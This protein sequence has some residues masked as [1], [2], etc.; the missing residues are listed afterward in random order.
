MTDRE[1]RGT[2]LAIGPPDPGGAAVCAPGPRLGSALPSQPTELVYDT[3]LEVEARS[4]WAFARRRFVRHRLA[5]GSL[6]VLL[7]VFGCRRLRQRHRALLLLRREHQRAD[8]AA[9]RTAS[10]RHRP[11]GSR[12]LQPGALRHP[13]I[14][15]GRPPRRLPLDGPRHHRRR[16]RRLLRRLGGQRPDAD[17]R[18]LFDLTPA[19]GPVDRGEIPRS[20]RAH[21]SG[22]AL[23]LLHLAD[24]RPH[25]SRNLSFAARE[26][27]R[28][29][30]QGV[31]IG[32]HPDHVQAHDPEH[33]RADPRR[34]DAHDRYRDPARVRRCR[35]SGSGSS[36]RRPRSVCSSARARI[37]ASPA[38][39][40][41]P[42]RVS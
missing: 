36:R 20:Q 24:D 12:L 38:G 40:W 18:P 11:G 23:S 16:S 6:I 35:S 2:G 14:G 39:G 30:G 22:A 15:P 8:R 28:G 5:M 4:Q 29:G 31:R 13:H 41:S 21:A 33:D 7:I 26:G 32:R 37:R 27:V 9:E 19:R 25:R 17:H 42:S 3:G 34:C 10:V 1:S